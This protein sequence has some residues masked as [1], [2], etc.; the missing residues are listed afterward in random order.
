VNEIIA[1]IIGSLVIGEPSIR[2]SSV[3]SKSR[4]AATAMTIAATINCGAF[5]RSQANR[6]LDAK[7][8]RLNPILQAWIY[9]RLFNYQQKIEKRKEYTK[10]LFT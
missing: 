2:T 6:E 4:K 1:A 8:H 3:I 9:Y 7:C 10:S 5:R